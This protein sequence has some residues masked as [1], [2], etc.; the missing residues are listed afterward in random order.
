LSRPTAASA[1]PPLS[2]S[3]PSSH[4]WAGFWLGLML[5]VLACQWAVHQRHAIAGR[6][7]ELFPL[8]QWLC[9]PVSCDVH[10]PM[11][12]DQVSLESSSFKKAGEH[13]FV[14]EGVVKNLGDS[15]LTP[16]ALELTLN[17]DGR[18]VVRKVIMPSELGLTEPLRPRG[19]HAFFLSFKLEPSLSPTIDG[20]KAL[21]FYP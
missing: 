12:P 17:A 14:F 4:G 1:D 3:E 20:Y 5:L 13:A 21:L 16:P 15:V 6:V 8:L 9:H 18:D 11:D 19:N 7:P 10:L 2:V